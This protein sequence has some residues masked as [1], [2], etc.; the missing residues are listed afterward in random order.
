[1][2][3]AHV[4]YPTVG[5]GGVEDSQPFTIAY[6]FGIGMA[7]NG[8]VT[9][10]D[11]IKKHLEGESHWHVNSAC[12]LEGI[13]N[14]FGDELAQQQVGRLKAEHVFKAV[15]GVFRRVKG[16]S[17]GGPHRGRRAVRSVIRRHQAH[18]HGQRID[19]K[20]CR[21]VASPASRCCSTSST[22]TQHD[23]R[24]GEPCS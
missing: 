19:E 15:E 6:P 1:M 11:E 8:N 20:G 12:D 13:L 9:N 23:I 21:S 16:W 14:I 22:S 3:I 7:H 5:A 17:C 4:R 24:V 10:F 18:H 2:G